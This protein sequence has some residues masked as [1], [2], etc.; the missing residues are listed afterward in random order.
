MRNLG[1]TNLEKLKQENPERYIKLVTCKLAG[2]A[3][4]L[5]LDDLSNLIIGT[6][7]TRSWD[8]TQNWHYLRQALYSVFFIIKGVTVVFNENEVRAVWVRITGE[9]YWYPNYSY[10]INAVTLPEPLDREMSKLGWTWCHKESLMAEE[11]G[12]LDFDY[13]AR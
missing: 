13:T 5:F 7:A 9:T 11:L 6:D 3:R 12:L 1:G 2:D 8:G 10:H 4:E